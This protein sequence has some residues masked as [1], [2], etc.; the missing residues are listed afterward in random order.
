MQNIIGAAA[1]LF[2]SANICSAGYTIVVNST[3]ADEPFS[4][5]GYGE[6]LSWSVSYGGWAYP[7][8]SSDCCTT[9]LQWDA[10]L[11]FTAAVWP[12][13]EWGGELS[14]GFSPMVHG[15]VST[16]ATAHYV[17]DWEDYTPAALVEWDANISGELK[18]RAGWS[19]DLKYWDDDLNEWVGPDIYWLESAS[20]ATIS[21][22]PP[23]GMTGGTIGIWGH[24]ND[25]VG[26]TNT[27]NATIDWN[28]FET[29]SG[30]FNN[31]AYAGYSQHVLFSISYQ[32]SEEMHNL[33]PT[34]LSVSPSLEGHANASALL[35]VDGNWENVGVSASASSSVSASI[36]YT[37]HSEF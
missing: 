4:D 7:S 6:A 16:S 37:V 25:E 21:Y 9:T 3:T 11:V 17:G 33:P 14:E 30:T 35:W 27:L 23:P 22:S 28:D 20:G 36:L 19:Y 2:T 24:L 13:G 34:G 1:I 15:E 10:A 26:G 32:G 5:S 8:L 29:D 18:M 12:A 31:S